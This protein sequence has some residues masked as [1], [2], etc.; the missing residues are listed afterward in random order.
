MRL[1][2]LLLA[3]FAFF[4]SY[5]QKH[6]ITGSLKDASTGEDL[7][8]ASIFN[9]R[10]QEGT[11]TNAYGFFSLTQ[12]QDSIHLRISYVG[13][14]TQLIKFYLPSDT[15]LRIELQSGTQLKE[16]EI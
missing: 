1:S 4:N 10:S 3:V 5:S 11:T 14:Q 12:Q 6:T 15:T 2:S 16:V 8:G 9:A 7:I 13:Y